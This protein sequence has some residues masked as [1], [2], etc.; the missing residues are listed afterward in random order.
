MGL[1]DSGTM[2]LLA[3]RLQSFADR[4]V[5]DDTGLAGNFEWTLSMPSSELA[6]DQAGTLVWAVQDQL[7]LKLQQRT[8]PMDVLVVDSVEM[9][10]PN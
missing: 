10:T 9:P 8:A 1:G 7:G 6:T 3:K 2:R 5:I 4:I